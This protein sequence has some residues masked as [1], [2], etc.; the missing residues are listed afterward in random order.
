[1]FTTP[2][3]EEIMAQTQAQLE[4]MA[5]ESQIQCGGR[6]CWGSWVLPCFSPRDQYIAVPAGTYPDVIVFGPGWL[7]WLPNPNPGM[8][9]YVRHLDEWGHIDLMHPRYRAQAHQV[10]AD[11][12]P[13]IYRGLGPYTPQ[14]RWVL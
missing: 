1:M 3:I 14:P 4:R 6:V 13:Y 5:A 11:W 9:N 10:Q 7:P 12:S 8:V 2:T